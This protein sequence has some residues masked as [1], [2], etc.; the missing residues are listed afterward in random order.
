V[1][2]RGGIDRALRNPGLCALRP[3]G[4]EVVRAPRRFYA[5]HRRAYTPRLWPM[6][7][8]T[9]LLVG[10]IAVATNPTVLEAIAIGAGVALV[11]GVTRWEIWKHR[12]PVITP[13]EYITDLQRKAR[14]N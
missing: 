13:A 1:F 6:L 5:A 11:V 7:L 14:W 9:A 3:E 12:H 2:R 10:A 4:L 8:G